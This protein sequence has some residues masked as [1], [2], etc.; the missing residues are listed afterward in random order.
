M[1]GLKNVVVIPLIK[2]LNALTDTDNLNNYKPVSNLLYVSKLTKR[3]V[4][5]SIETEDCRSR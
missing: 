2:E 5:R 1:E 3:V 4:A